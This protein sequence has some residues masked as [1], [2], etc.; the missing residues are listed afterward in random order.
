M[1]SGPK[2]NHDLLLTGAIFLLFLSTALRIMRALLTT[3]VNL[4]F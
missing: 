1:A 3:L 4:F 2:K